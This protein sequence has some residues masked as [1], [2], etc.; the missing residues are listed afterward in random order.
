MN[1]FKSGM[2]NVYVKI[3]SEIEK[4]P[5]LVLGSLIKTQGSTPQTPGASAVFNSEGLIYGTLGGGILEAEAQKKALKA[6]DSKQNI[7]EEFNF[8]AG[9]DDRTGAICG[10]SAVF[11]LDANP[12]KSMLA[13]QQMKK[14]LQKK[15]AG[16][17]I[18]V[19][20]VSQTKNVSVIRFWFSVD[21]KIPFD[22]YKEYLL[23][24]DEFEPVLERKKSQII[25]VD[26]KINSIKE[27]ETTIFAEPVFPDPELI[28]VGAGHIGQALCN[29]GSFLDFD[30]I[31]L[32]NRLE[33]A[34]KERFPGANRIIVR[35]ITEGLNDI[36]ISEN[37]F[38]VIVTQG[39]REDAE[40]LK[41]CIKSNAAYIGMIGSKRK[42]TLIREKFINEGICSEKEFSRVYAPVGIDIKS[43]TVQE[44]A[45]SIAAQLINIRNLK[46]EKNEKI[47]VWCIVLAAG[48]SK[49]M[50]QQKLLMPYQGKT[51]IERVVDTAICSKAENILVV[52]GS[53][54]KNVEKKI[55][56]PKVLTVEN[57]NFKEGMLSSIRCGINS[58]PGHVKA[59]IIQL[60]DQPMVK[61]EVID[62]LIGTYKNG[63]KGIIIPTFEGKRGHPILLDLKFR[64][65]INSLDS[66]TGLRGLLFNHP[67]EIQEVEVNSDDILKD[68]DT[69][70]DYQKELK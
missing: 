37:S 61:T 69:P 16:I 54:K 4:N 13:F 20:E 62:N 60:G 5:S 1:D 21:E 57:K 42:I 12:N 9:I 28:I 52:L 66:E 49:R 50:K 23:G 47:P 56:H 18:T 29:L 44:I 25:K 43:E 30:V 64:K 24:W 26:E 19:I 68:I 46:Q 15:K 53:D 39:H 55:N 59:S 45:V 2:R 10:G 67:E 3:L 33:L 38:I 17:L 34:T 6:I 31:V 7:F 36:L 32:D 48:E 8:N 58:I 22:F 51:I 11:L 41:C 63:Q 35:N 27:K 14:A 70:E 65:E 40:A